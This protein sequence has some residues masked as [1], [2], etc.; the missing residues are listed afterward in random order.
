MGEPLKSLSPRARLGA[1]LPA[2]YPG[3]PPNFEDVSDESTLSLKEVLATISTEDATLVNQIRRF[4]GP[5][6]LS[7]ADDHDHKILTASKTFVADMKYQRGALVGHNCKKLQG[8]KQSAVND[9]CNKQ[10]SAA[11]RANEDVHVVLRNY[12]GAGE[13]FGNSLT[14]LVLRDANENAVYRLGVI[15]TVVAPPEGEVV[16]PK[17]KSKSKKPAAKKPSARK[18]R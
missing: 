9:A 17:K 11:F 15:K 14:V 2:H 5:W 10:L 8:S 12:D 1:A 6:L 16:A 18:K 4:R 7:R 3:T 13:A